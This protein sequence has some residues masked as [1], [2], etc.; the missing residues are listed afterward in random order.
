MCANPNLSRKIDV[1]A[2]YLPPGYADEMRSGGLVHPD[3]MPDYPKWSVELALEA[4]DKLGIE[5]GV[6]SISSPGVHYGNDAAARRLARKVNEAGAEAVTKHPQRFGLFAA[7][8]IPDVEGSL[9]E[10]AYAMDTLNADG[11]GL[12]TNTHG[13]YLGDAK[14][15]PIFQEL[16]RRKAVVFIHPTSPSCW[17]QCAMG[18]PAPMI[19]FPFDTARAV[20]NL[21][22]SGTLERCP[23]VTIIVPHNGGALP[24]LAGRIAAVGGRLRLG[25]AGTRDAITYLRRLYYDTAIQS[26]HTLSSLLQLAD[27]GQIVYGSD[28]PWY[29][30][31]AGL[32]TN[33]ELEE[34]SFF[35][36]QDRE[37][38]CRSNALRLLPRIRG[39]S[40]KR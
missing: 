13:V 4:Y 18:Y 21:I 7:L 34:G 14:F 27:V 40:A 30:E 38:I 26:K 9:D 28:W 17:Q 10:L 12:K 37:A 6:L 16:N 29:P 23:D 36:D 31:A 24:I 5:T 33:K 3:G 19:E 20:T 22:F 1:H 8:P 11:I 15:E 25:P 2:H 39:L 32:E 35:S